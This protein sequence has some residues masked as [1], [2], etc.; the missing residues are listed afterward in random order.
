MSEAVKYIVNASTSLSL[1]LAWLAGLVIAK[2]F[3]M[4]ACA[5]FPPYAW[6]L[7]VELAMKP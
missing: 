6:Y 2:G 3:W 4:T 7:V 1:G 5:L